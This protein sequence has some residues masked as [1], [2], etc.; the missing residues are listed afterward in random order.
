VEKTSPSGLPTE[1]KA[2]NQKTRKRG[3][4]NDEEKITKAKKNRHNGKGM[5]KPNSPPKRWT[6]PLFG[7]KK[8]HS[9]AGKKESQR[10]QELG[11]GFSTYH[12]CTQTRKNAIPK[13][14]AEKRTGAKGPKDGV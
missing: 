13:G 10:K 1:V 3:P 11:N 4:A 8:R 12:R 9:K 7:K 14:W 6:Q 2:K 5:D